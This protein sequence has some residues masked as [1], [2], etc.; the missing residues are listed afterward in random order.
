[1]LVDALANPSLA[2]ASSPGPTQILFRSRGEK[3]GECLGAKYVTTGNGGLSY[4][5]MWTQ[6]RNDGNVPTH[7][8]AGIIGQFNPPRHFCQQLPTSQVPS[9]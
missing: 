8:V 4:Y 3:S 2:I 7:N 9:H 5:V 6:F 1:M